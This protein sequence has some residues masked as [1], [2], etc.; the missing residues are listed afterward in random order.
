MSLNPNGSHLPAL[1]ACVAVTDGPVLE[2][3]LGEF[4]TPV[5]HALCFR[6]RKLVSLDH[7]Q[8]AL[9]NFGCLASDWHEVRLDPN[10]ASLDRLAREPWGVVLVDH[11]PSERRAADALKFLGAEF[12][13][14]HD[15]EAQAIG[16]PIMA[17]AINAGLRVRLY[18][19]F[20]PWTL[21]VG[22]KEIPNLP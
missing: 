3:G 12:V 8:R 11:W 14:V 19:R 1:V 2:L 9:D 17:K 4:S 21:I 10:Y 5:L 18:Q 22:Q 6:G 7:D 20:E 16:P 15:A 13:V